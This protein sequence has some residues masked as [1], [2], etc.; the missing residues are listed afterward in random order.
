MEKKIYFLEFLAGTC[1]PAPASPAVNPPHQ[2][3][4]NSYNQLETKRTLA[5]TKNLTWIKLK[6]NQSLN[7]Q[8]TIRKIDQIKPPEFRKKRCKK[9]KSYNLAL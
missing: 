1:Y 3:L 8:K 5:A 2:Q 4:R 7:S 6:F 9:Q